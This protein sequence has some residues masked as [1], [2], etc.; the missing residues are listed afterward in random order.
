[1]GRGRTPSTQIGSF[2]FVLS[3]GLGRF[4]GLASFFPNCEGRGMSM[5]QSRCR[6][7]SGGGPDRAN[8]K[9]YELGG[10][11]QGV[12]GRLAR[13]RAGFAGAD[14]AVAVG[15][16]LAKD[17]RGPQKLAGREDPVPIAVDHFK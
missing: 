8:H 7:P 12:R 17:L 3:L 15:V 14:R 6:S 10:R 4:R 9:L 2:F 5:N 16:E 13:G 11:T 1:M